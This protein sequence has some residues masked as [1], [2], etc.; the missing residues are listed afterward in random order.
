MV[1]IYRKKK[2]KKLLK[3]VDKYKRLHYNKSIKKIQK[4]LN[5][6]RISNLTEI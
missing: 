3:I 5:N 2:N 6:R 4:F 1:D